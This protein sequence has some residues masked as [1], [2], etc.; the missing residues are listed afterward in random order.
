VAAQRGGDVDRPCPTEHSDRQV[1][2]DR[3]DAWGG[4]GAD[5][6]IVLGEGGVAD[7]VHRLDRPVSAQQV[8]QA[9]GAGQP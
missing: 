7:V 5:L 2:Q 1:P 6:R 8:G 3:H 4:A 9:G